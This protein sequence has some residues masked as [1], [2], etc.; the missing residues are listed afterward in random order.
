MKY[1]YAFDQ[2]REDAPN[3]AQKLFMGYDWLKRHYLFVDP[4][5]Y[6]TADSGTID[7][8]TPQQAC[9]KLFR[10]YNAKYNLVGY[11]GRSMSVSDIVNLWDNSKEPPEKTSWYCDSIGFVCISKET[12][13]L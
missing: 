11:A 4:D 5:D 6:F 13:Y 1:T 10:F 9:E 12:R 8:E 7:A 3:M 2:L